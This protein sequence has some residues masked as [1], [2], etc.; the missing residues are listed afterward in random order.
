MRGSAPVRFERCAKVATCASI[1]VEGP[2]ARVRASQRVLDR[3]SVTGRGAVE[4]TCP[5]SRI[6]HGQ[7]RRLLT[8][9]IV[10]SRHWLPFHGLRVAWHTFCSWVGRTRRPRRLMMN[11]R[12]LSCSRALSP[13]LLD[14]FDRHENPVPID[15]S[16]LRPSCT[17]AATPPP[18]TAWRLPGFVRC[19]RAEP[20]SAPCGSGRRGPR[21]RRDGAS[22]RGS[23]RNAPCWH[24]ATWLGACSGAASRRSASRAFS[25]PR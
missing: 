21:S 12:L 18:R 23:S 22:T 2:R 25:S 4:S 24:Y 13:T 8:N 16:E 15:P 20:R 7:G 19:L 10:D 14:P 9:P 1:G 6:R 11:L 5:G 3:A 17:P